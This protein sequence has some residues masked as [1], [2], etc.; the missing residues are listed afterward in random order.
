VCGDKRCRTTELDGRIYEQIPRE[1]VIKAALVA[2]TELV[3]EAKPDEC[4]G[5]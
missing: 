4:C 1:L 5:Y 3:G 2:A